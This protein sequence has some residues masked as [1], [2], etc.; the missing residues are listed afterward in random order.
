MNWQIQKA[1]SRFKE[2]IE[3]VFEEGPQTV[4]RH[5]KAVAIVIP[6]EEY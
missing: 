1:K 3:R 2:L 5:G 4:T 6:I